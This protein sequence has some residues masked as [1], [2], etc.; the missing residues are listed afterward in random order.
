MV[1]VASELAKALPSHGQRQCG[2]LRL[3]QQQEVGPPGGLEERPLAERP[4]ER[5]RRGVDGDEGSLGPVQGRQ[6][7]LVRALVQEKVPGDQ[8]GA[9]LQP[10]GHIDGRQPGVGPTI[11]HHR[12][13]AGFVDHEHRARP[14]AR[15]DG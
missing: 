12:S 5:P 3:V 15:I 1:E 4:D 2:R 11:R 7:P 10:V 13:L 6:G 8:H 14:G 9:G